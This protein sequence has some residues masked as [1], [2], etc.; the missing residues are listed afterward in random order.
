MTKVNAPDIYSFLADLILVCHT[1]FIVFVLAG[2][3]LILMGL[4]L[5]WTW[6]KNFW[7]RLAHLLAIIGVIVWPLTGRICPLTI[8]ESRLR[9]AAGGRSH[10]GGFLQHYIH[11]F[12]YYDFP[13]W[14]FS[15]LY[16]LFGMLVI[17]VWL[18]RPP[19]WPDCI[20]TKLSQTEK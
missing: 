14:V 5:K 11:Q 17:I 13:L 3:I 4:G 9:T 19:Q 15:I 18:V 20:R 2:F 12:I 6:I 8:W 1:L 16:L 10:T 7:F